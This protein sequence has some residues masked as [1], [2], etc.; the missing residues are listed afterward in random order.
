MAPKLL[1]LLLFFFFF[2]DADANA[3][4]LCIGALFGAFTLGLLH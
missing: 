2:A 3:L 4:S 1:L